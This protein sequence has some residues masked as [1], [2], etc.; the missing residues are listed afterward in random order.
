MD[1]GIRGKHVLVTGASR[2]IGKEIARAFAAEGCRLSIVAR[3]HDKL[4]SLCQELGGPQAGHRFAA[5]DLTEP[6]KPTEVVDLFM[7]EGGPIDIVVHNL[8]AS[9]GSREILAPVEEWQ[10]LWQLNVGVA[11]EI[12]NRVIPAMADRKWGRI[13]MIS[14]RA[15][16]TYEGAGPYAAAKAYLNAYMTILARDAAKS[17]IV[18]SG[19]MPGIV[20]AEGN[21]WEKAL[22]DQPE[23]VE[24]IIAQRISSGRF[25]TAGDIAPFVVFLASDLNRYGVGT[26]ISVDGGFV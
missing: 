7:A 1:L 6:A 24:E 5:A 11:I 20:A 25:G 8:G 12:N 22:H 21:N 14:S 15:G 10:R 2:G 16:V 13:V 26:L 9:L 18:V 17:G 23:K 4:Q 3:Q 19:V